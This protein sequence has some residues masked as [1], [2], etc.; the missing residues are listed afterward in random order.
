MDMAVEAAVERHN[1]LMRARGAVERR[2]QELLAAMSRLT[3]A[4]LAEYVRQTEDEHQ[5]G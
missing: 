2:N 4:Q 3:P 1:A 5:R